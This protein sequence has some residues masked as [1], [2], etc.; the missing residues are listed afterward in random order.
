MGP[1]DV[2][3]APTAGAHLATPTGSR[4]PTRA[5]QRSDP[6]PGGPERRARRR[7]IALLSG[8]FAL[9]IV[10]VFALQNLHTARV[11][12]LGFAWSAPLGLMLLSASL[13]GGIVVFTLGSIRIVQLRKPDRGRNGKP[14]RRSS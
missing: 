4:V 14:Q 2:Q 8:M 11:H 1:S 3:Q 6:G 13:L 5:P 12:F 9:L 7:W 10:L